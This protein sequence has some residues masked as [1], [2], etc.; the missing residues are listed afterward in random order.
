MGVADVL[1]QL[2]PSHAEPIDNLL[3]HS[4]TWSELNYLLVTALNR[5]I[6]LMQVQHIAMLVGQN[7][8][9]NVLGLANEFLQ[10]HG[11]IAK[12]ALGLRLRLCE[13]LFQILF[14]AHDPHSSPATAKGRL[15]DQRKSNLLR[16][17]HCLDAVVDRLLSPLENRNLQLLGDTPRRRLVAHHVQK[18]WIRPNE[19]DARLFTCPGKLRVF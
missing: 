15:D 3:I 12:R 6:P 4:V 17:L 18:L 8:H 19:G 16:D 9:L 1:R 2:Q 5:A 10:E 13:Q 11:T 7:L 14:F